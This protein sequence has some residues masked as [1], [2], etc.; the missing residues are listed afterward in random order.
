MSATDKVWTVADVMIEDVISVSPDTSFK[1]L[2]DLLW[3][4][5]AS[6]LPVVDRKGVLLG[7]V[8]ES[9][10]LVRAQFIPKGETESAA[11]SSHRAQILGKLEA[12]APLVAADVM[13]TPVVTVRPDATL[14]DTARLM[15]ARKLRRLPVLDAAGALVGM[16]SQLD[17]LKVFFRSEETMEW[18]V[19]DVL[20]RRLA[21]PDGVAVRV[22][23]GVVH[24]EG[25]APA[26]PDTDRLVAAIDSLPGVV[27][28]EVSLGHEGAAKSARRGGI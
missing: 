4:N 24:L 2:V 10:L 20:Q 11:G 7:I 27:A 6:A 14:S 12:A 1:R 3:I 5:D 19:R 15:R 28:V 9:D 18:D 17:L 16:V 13:T 26:S 8:T 21:N 22:V 23:D 25:L